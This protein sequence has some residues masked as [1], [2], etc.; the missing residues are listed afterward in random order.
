VKA[1]DHV[2]LKADPAFRAVVLLD[3]KGGV[4]FV[5]PA[6]WGNQRRTRDGVVGL[7]VDDLEVINDTIEMEVMKK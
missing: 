4:V 1:G 6:S 5:V 7:H 2:V 3:P